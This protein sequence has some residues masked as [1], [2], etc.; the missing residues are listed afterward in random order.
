MNRVYNNNNSKRITSTCG[1]NRCDGIGAVS[2][3]S[4]VQ[5][6]RDDRDQNRAQRNEEEKHFCR[7][8]LRTRRHTHT[9]THAARLWSAQVE[10]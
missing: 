2:F 4:L 6:V 1:W 10:K 5:R 7:I 8:P 3:K 9:L